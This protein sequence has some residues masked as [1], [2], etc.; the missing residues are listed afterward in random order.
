SSQSQTY[1][2]FKHDLYDYLTASIDTKYGKSQFNQRLYTYVQEILPDQDAQCLNDVL[3]VGTCRKLLNFLIVESC[4][5]LNHANFVDLTGNLGTTVTIGLLLKIVLIC[6]NVKPYLEKRFS[7]LFNHYESCAR[8]GVVWLI[9]S[10]ESLNVAFSI[11]FG[12][13]SL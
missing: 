10:L 11:N 13:L 4:Q 6:R 1:R 5:N 7:I 12:T 8:D 3:L 9:E 2:V